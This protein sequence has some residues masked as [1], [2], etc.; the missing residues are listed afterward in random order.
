MTVAVVVVA[1]ILLGCASRQT[2]RRRVNGDDDIVRS[3]RCRRSIESALNSLKTGTT[4]DPNGGYSR[5][6]S[7]EFLVALVVVDRHLL[8][9]PCCFFMLYVLVIVF[10]S[11][12]I[13]F[14]LVRSF[15]YDKRLSE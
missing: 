2:G 11:F 15:F 5:N 6:Q 3:G 1:D 7:K 9:R 14:S 8:L 13:F 10:V 12:A 4:Q